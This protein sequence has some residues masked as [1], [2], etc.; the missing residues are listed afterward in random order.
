MVEIMCRN[1]HFMHAGERVCSACGEPRIAPVAGGPRG[2][3]IESVVV[4]LLDE[5]TGWY[6]AALILP[7]AECFTGP[8]HSI[9]EQAEYDAAKLREAV[10]EPVTGKEE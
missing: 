1:Q 5:T 10:G 7:T 3:P 9:H 2:Q 4:V 8:P 6:H